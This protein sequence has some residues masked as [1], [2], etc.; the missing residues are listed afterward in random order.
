MTNEVEMKN[1]NS[2]VGV[3]EMTSADYYK[4]HYAHFGNQ[5]MLLTNVSYF[6]A[7]HEEMLKDDVRTR[8][9]MNS[10][11]RNKHLFRNK[12]VL[13]IGCGTGMMRYISLIFHRLIRPSAFLLQ[14]LVQRKSLAST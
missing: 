4:D 13:D 2:P 10:I 5:L 11:I 7:I 1:G 12:V 3:G 6:I 8:A 14:V 9:Y